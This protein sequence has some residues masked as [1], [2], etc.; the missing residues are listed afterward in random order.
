MHRSHGEEGG[1]DDTGDTCP[2]RFRLI[3]LVK[4]EMLYSVIKEE[5]YL[6]LIIIN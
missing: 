6:S 5:S 2:Y 1:M 4:S 3:K